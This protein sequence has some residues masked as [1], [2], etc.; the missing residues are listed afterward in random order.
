V[1]FVTG[2]R[3]VYG[4]LTLDCTQDLNQGKA[5]GVDFEDGGHISM[6]IGTFNN[7]LWI[8]SFFGRPALVTHVITEAPK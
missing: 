1:F 6:R 7:Q 4:Y 2:Y 8:R 3:F 5:G